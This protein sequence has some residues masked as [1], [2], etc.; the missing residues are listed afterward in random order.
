M[1]AIKKTW[2]ASLVLSA[3]MG[4]GSA[5]LAADAAKG[6]L[7]AEED[8]D[9]ALIST[10]TNIK[11]EQTIRAQFPNSHIASVTPSP[12]PGL[13][14]VV[15]G[16]NVFYVAPGEDYIIA[17]HIYDTKAQKDI[18]AERKNELGFSSVEQ[19]ASANSASSASS[20]NSRAE[21]DRAMASPALWGKVPTDMAITSGP[22][23]APA[24]VVFTDP[25]CPHC[26]QFEQML[27]QFEPLRVYRVPMS[28]SPDPSARAGL[29]NAMCD[30]D[31]FTA[32]RKLMSGGSVN[33]AP[34]ACAREASDYLDRVEKFASEYGVRGTPF[35]LKPDGSYRIGF[36]PTNFSN[37]VTKGDS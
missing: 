26:A 31:P 18:T 36:N 7:M 15:A 17:G 24:V 35:F 9:A 19:G 5:A 27:P 14:E 6:K 8:A 29:V 28:L 12:I 23:N 10:M 21:D 22:V 4:A 32:Y 13:Y 20:A 33:Q 16:R 34:A 3:S 37:W 11:A 2:L 1:K 30:D 25:N